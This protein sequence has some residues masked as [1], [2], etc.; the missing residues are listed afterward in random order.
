MTAIS[1]RFKRIFVVV[2]LCAGTWGTLTAWADK[3][4]SGDSNVASATVDVGIIVGDIEKSLEFYTQGLGFRE[5]GTIDVSA[6][7]GKDFGLTSGHAFHVHV[8]ALGEGEGAT[9]VKL[10]H[11]KDAPGKSVDN[12][13]IHSTHGINY[14]T[15]F[16]KDLDAAVKGAAAV[17]ARPLAKGPVAIP[18]NIA[19]GLHLAT[20]RDPDGNMIELIGPRS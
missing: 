18:A 17:G 1:H 19:P 9:K 4:S 5:V 8:L 20:V 10:M 11:F 2:V 6:Q 12:K 7:L 13:Y 3:S 16:V 14:L 15:M